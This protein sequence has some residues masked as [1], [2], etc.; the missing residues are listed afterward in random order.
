D[1]VLTL[2]T[3]RDVT[4]IREAATPGARIVVLGGGFIG[5]EAA[6]SLRAL[7]CEVVLVDRNPVPG[8]R[9]LGEVLA[10]WLHG[11]HAAA[12]VDVRVTGIDSVEPAPA[13]LT[14]RLTDGTSL[15]A[16]LV[17]AGVGMLPQVP[18]PGA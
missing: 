1:R 7:G 14:V 9:V 4:R 16:A 12:G 17:V 13:G 6:A 11:L 2:R 15:E 18:L 3:Y 5:A 8:A 10:G